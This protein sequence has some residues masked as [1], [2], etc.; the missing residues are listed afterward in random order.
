M[1][2]NTLNQ[3]LL[4]IGVGFWDVLV[5]PKGRAIPLSIRYEI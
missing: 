2:T 5:I 3:H 4:K 1:L